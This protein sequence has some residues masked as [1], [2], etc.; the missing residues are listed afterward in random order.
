[1]DNLVTERGPAQPLD[2]DRV[3]EDRAKSI[4]SR[5][6]PKSPDGEKA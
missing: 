2:I 3:E 1:M 4:G 6:K 5:N